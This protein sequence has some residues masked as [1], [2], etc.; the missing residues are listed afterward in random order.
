MDNRLFYA[1]LTSV[2]PEQI[3]ILFD[4]Y[5]LDG[6]RDDSGDILQFLTYCIH[7]CEEDMLI[8][9]GKDGWTYQQIINKEIDNE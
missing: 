1:Q 4:S 8:E 9:R 2:L 6:Y 3:S 7:K 5:I